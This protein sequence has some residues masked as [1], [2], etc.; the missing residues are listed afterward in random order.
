MKGYKRLVTKDKVRLI[1]SRYFS[2]QYDHYYTQLEPY[3]ESFTLNEDQ[4]DK[5]TK[6]CENLHEWN[7]KV[8]LI[9]RK[10][11]E[12]LVPNHI[13]PSLSMS[14]VV[15]FQSNQSVIDVGTG[16]G[17]PGIPLAI[18]FPDTKFTLLD[19]NNKKMKIVND[20]SKSLNLN[21]VRCIV[22]RAENFDEKFDSIVGR[23]VSAIPN[24]L[25]F[26]SHLI[27]ENNN[28]DNSKTGLFYLKGGKYLDELQEV[29]ADVYKIY[30]I[31]NMVDLDTDKTVLHLPASWIINYRK[32]NLSNI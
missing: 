8:N 28:I 17:L 16:G 20:I 3:H 9:S 15:Q 7:Q 32:K 12:Y 29:G 13:L 1:F 4:W 26:S 2:S 30:N 18:A 11:I 22:S 14:L 19:S 21:N 24:F 23:A 10:D 27:K 31:N 5:L 6:L 25:S